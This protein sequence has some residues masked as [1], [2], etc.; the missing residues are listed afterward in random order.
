MQPDKISFHSNTFHALG[1]I[2]PSIFVYCQSSLGFLELGLSQLLVS[3]SETRF[4]PLRVMTAHRLRRR[5]GRHLSF[6]LHVSKWKELLH[7]GNFKETI[8]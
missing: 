2:P 3:L 8:Y 5:M 4:Q 7:K 6:H 1:V